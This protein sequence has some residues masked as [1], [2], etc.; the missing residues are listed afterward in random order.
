MLFEAHK[1]Y[2]LDEQT[3]WG[4]IKDVTRHLKYWDSI[5]KECGISRKEIDDFS[6]RIETGL[7]WK[8]GDGVLKI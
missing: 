5:A 8:Y 1:S 6:E 4:I 7:T 3:A 2:M